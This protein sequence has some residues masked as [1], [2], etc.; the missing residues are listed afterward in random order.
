LKNNPYEPPS[1]PT[2]EKKDLRIDP[3]IV[4][5]EF[6]IWIASLTAL[7]FLLDSVRTLKIN[8]IKNILLVVQYVIDLNN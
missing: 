5:K 7:F 4:Y 1:F 6:L 2:Q 8:I 3:N